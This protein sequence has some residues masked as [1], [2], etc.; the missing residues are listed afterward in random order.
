MSVL[1][2]NG[3][4]I[5][6]TIPH[7]NH[8]VVIEWGRFYDMKTLVCIF[9]VFIEHHCSTSMPQTSHDSVD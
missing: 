9:L 8:T 6:Y 2:E 7:W 3:L 5:F 1:K 4:L